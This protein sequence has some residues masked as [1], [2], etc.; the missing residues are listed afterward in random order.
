M[1]REKTLCSRWVYWVTGRNPKL[2]IPFHSLFQKWCDFM[3]LG[4]ADAIQT[5]EQEENE[6][7]AEEVRKRTPK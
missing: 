7:M 2:E 3:G 1:P 6:C 4:M 5:F